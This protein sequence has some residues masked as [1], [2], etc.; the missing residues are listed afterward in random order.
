M[1]EFNE[2]RFMAVTLP[3]L[4]DA[5]LVRAASLAGEIG[6]VN[7]EFAPSTEGLRTA[8]AAL[9]DCPQGL[10]GVRL[11]MSDSMVT[12]AILKDLPQVGWIILSA[13]EPSVACWCVQSFRARGLRVLVETLDVE[14]ARAAEAAGA[15]GVIA[16]GNESGGWVAEEPAFVLLQRL[17]RAVNLPVW[18]QGG[19]G[20]HTSASAFVG[21]AAGVVLDAQ[22]ALLRESPLPD[23]VR[24]RVAT[25][26]GSETV[27]LGEA[28][29]M[30]FRALASPQSETVTALQSLAVRL[31]VGTDTA[32]AERA[33]WR[34]EIRRSV[35]WAPSCLWPL[36]QDAC[37]AR[38]L[39]ERYGT[40]SRALRGLRS[41]LRSEL[42]AAQ[43]VNI[44]MEES[45][46]SKAHGTVYPIVQ[47]PMTRV[48]DTPAFAAE[49]AAAG[50]LPF[51]ALGTQREAELETLLA[52]T[53]RRLDNRPWG[54]GLLGFLDGPL[55]EEQFAVV[56]RHRPP[57]ALIAGGQPEQA[58][59]LE[60]EGIRTY[61]HA[62]TP[63]L[64]ALFREEGA[65]RFVLEGRECGGHVGPLSSF[66]LWEQAARMLLETLPADQSSDCHI[67]LAGGIHDARSAAMAA[68]CMAPLAERG[69]K[70]G[71]LMGTA[72]LF[73]REA[74]SSGAILEVF[75]RQALAC[76]HT[77]LL[78]TG[79]GHVVRCAPTPYTWSFNTLKARRLADGASLEQVRRELEAMNI[80]RLRLAAKGVSRRND[81][82]HNLQPVDENEQ[83]AEGLYMLGQAAGLREEVCTVK[84]L[85]H[86]VSPGGSKILREATR[87]VD[88]CAPRP[89][90]KRDGIAI[91]GMS[92][93]LPGARDP[94]QFWANILN[95]V[96][97]I[98]EVPAERWDWKLY[99]DERRDAADRVYARWGG[100]LDP[101]AFDPARY[102]MPPS[103]IASI[104]PIQLL[105]LETAR[106]A[107]RDAG[108]EDRP[109]PRE[110]TSVIIGVS[111]GLAELGQ[112]YVLRSALAARP[113]QSALA[114]FNRKL[115]EW[116][117]DSFAGILLNVIAGRIANRFDLGGPSFAVDA[118][119]ASSLT[120]VYLACRELE[121]GASDMVLVGGADTFQT[122]FNYLCFCKTQALS[123]R[124]CCRTFD[125]AADG[126]CISEGLSMLVLKRLADA[127]LD[128]DRIYAV[129]R[130]VGASSD[131][132]AKG[133]TAPSPEGQAR[134]LHR[135]YAAANISPA[136]VGLVEAHGTGTV[137][138]DR[139]EIESLRRI[140]EEAG[141]SPQSVALGSVKSMI[142][143]TKG[144]AGVTGLLK[145]ALALHRKVLP[146]TIG[147]EKPN[148]SIAGGA[149]Y[150]NT[151]TRPWLS[152]SQNYPRRAA[153]SGFGFGGAN[154]HVVVEE[155]VG[156]TARAAAVRWPCELFVWRE[157]SVDALLLSVARLLAALRSGA[158][159]SLKDLSFT[160]WQKAQQN[161]DGVVIAIVASS[162]KDLISKMEAVTN[163]LAAAPSNPIWDSSGVYFTPQ[164]LAGN[165][166]IA[167]L[168][169][170]QGSQYPDMLR[171]LAVHFTEVRE[172]FETADRVLAGRFDRPLSSFVFPP[173]R[174]SEEDERAARKALTAT[175]VAQPAL[176]AAAVGLTH[177]LRALNVKPAMTAGH[178]YGEYA[179]LCAA[180]CLTAEQLFEL[181]ESRG[182]FIV[183]AAR[184]DLGAMAA[185][186]TDEQ[187]TRSLMGD[188]TDLWIANLNSP[189]Q[190]IVSGTKAAIAEA[191]RRGEQRRVGVQSLPV[192]CAFHSPLVAAAKERLKAYLD[193]VRF[194]AP[195]YRVFTNTTGN[196]YPTEPDAVRALLG[197]H[198]VSPVRFVSEI[199]SMYAAGARVF[200]EVGP[201]N[202][203]TSLTE[204]ILSQRAS[205]VVPLE[206]RKRVGLEGLLHALAQLFA[207][208]VAIKL[209]RLYEERKPHAYLLERLAEETREKP[210]PA[211]AWWV[212]GGHARPVYTSTAETAK[213]Q[214]S[215]STENTCPNKETTM[216]APLPSASACAEQSR[217][218]D[219]ASALQTHEQVMQQLLDTHRRV[220]LAAL[221]KSEALPE[222]AT[223]AG[224]AVPVAPALA[225]AQ[226][227]PGH[228]TDQSD[229]TDRSPPIA[230]ADRIRQEVLRIVSERTGY[231]PDM[232]DVNADLEADLGIDSI[233]RVEIAGR[234]RKVFPHIGAT[235]ETSR[236]GNLANLRTLNALI[237]RIASVLAAGETTNGGGKAERSM[238]QEGLLQAHGERPGSPPSSA[239]LG[240]SPAVSAGLGSPSVVTGTAQPGAPTAA[241][242]ES[243]PPE[244]N[245]QQKAAEGKLPDSN[246]CF[247]G[248]EA[249]VHVPR[250]MMRFA[251]APSDRKERGGMR[252]DGVFLITDDEKGLADA[253]A[254]HIVS[255]KGKA[256]IVSAREGGHGRVPRYQA[257]FSNPESLHL[258]VTA[259]CKAEGPVAGI[260][261]LLPLRR[262]PVDA[263]SLK[264]W[265]RTL[266]EEVKA[267][268]FLAQ[269][270][271]ED[272]KRPSPGGRGRI[273][274]AVEA[275]DT[276]PGNN[277]I[278]SLLNALTTEWPEV[279]GRSLALDT[280]EA[281]PVLVETICGELQDDASVR[282]VHL[283]NGRRRTVRI[284]TAPL[285]M[286]AAEPMRISS[287]W[288]ILLIGGA[289]GITA[290]VAIELAERFSPTLV[291]T[292]RSPQ[293]ATDEDPLT[294]AVE[295]PPEL[296][297]LLSR[298][299]SE[300][301]G[302]APLAQVEAAY[303]RL[304]REREIRATLAAL[305]ATGARVKYFQADARDSAAFG[306]T[307]DR[308]Y[309]EYGRLDGV[310][311]GAGVIEDKRIEEK[312]P[313]S[314]DRVFDTKA[315][316]AF[317][318]TQRLRLDSV[319]FIVF[320]SSVACLGNAGQSDYAAANGV[321]NG[322]AHDLDRRI[323][324]RVVSILWGPWQNTG[325]TSEEIQR[326]FRERGVQVIPVAAGR[327]CLVAELLYG[328]KGETEVLWG[329]AP[330][331]SATE[332][333]TTGHVTLPLIGK[334]DAVVHNN[335]TSEVACLL[336][337]DQHAYLR[338]HR[339]DGKPVF[340][341]AMAME[342]MAEAAWATAAPPLRGTIE[343][344]SL[345]VQSGIVLAKE[346]PLPLQV[347]GQRAA[348][349][350]TGSDA[351]L[352]TMEI[353]TPKATRRAH[354]RAEVTLGSQAKP[355]HLDPAYFAELDPF[356]LTV[357]E[358]YRQWLFQGPCFAALTA[359]EGIRHDAIVGR[360]QSVKPG[361]CGSAFSNSQW[362]LDPT[363]VDASLQLV[364]LWKRYWHDMTPLPVQISRFR[365]FYPLSNVPIRCFVKALAENDGDSLTADIYYADAQGHVLA[366]LEGLQCACSKELNRLS[367]HAAAQFA[368]N[369]RRHTK[370]KTA[371]G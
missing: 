144:A 370:R 68:A 220:M 51:L 199:E 139:A 236:V 87:T 364:I 348:V 255:L 366:V 106:A 12:P 40:V 105:A 222:S 250:F 207:H 162:M 145:V 22:L 226:A 169:P 310:I 177:L 198:L 323:P 244:V 6:V 192:A 97:A 284:E 357:E 203:L 19:I 109:F 193:R 123:P 146:A 78:E 31:A 273:L 23:A 339:L 163:K 156:S 171:E 183:E 188:I 361:A 34:A 215:A 356:P 66:V 174:F 84:E 101:I 36:G 325:M 147:V 114:G 121:S 202:V 112:N 287:D 213:Q 4:P 197:E 92:C 148:E 305:S 278:T 279:V 328:C 195:R 261:H 37:L 359:I 367:D 289:R 149:L 30:P 225:A 44:L 69:V 165:A 190:T 122:P 214:A 227:I 180:G 98:R 173:P 115:P 206:T 120:A 3:G 179:A 338:D 210:P 58:R 21:G 15:D 219:L 113:D 54:V 41:E 137:A 82:A 72:Y 290:Q 132:R 182:R 230:D 94:D 131:G 349:P 233:K 29:R 152:A 39:A 254:E 70:V 1:L 164:P 196:E 96:N 154:Y 88:E 239:E 184:G 67:L 136:T 292:G 204:Q 365:L 2:F 53:R 52:E 260:V 133:L 308:I 25:M 218:P 252:T 329:D 99:F 248:S 103:S 235:A 125:H 116:T 194:E 369:R 242:V 288:V 221:G 333:A 90:A 336:D 346:E 315:D 95:K 312:T 134:A 161:T 50:A 104:E 160:L 297:R 168:F 61:L 140:F 317:V 56:R 91:V 335:G 110:N 282:F 73:T 249:E 208:G 245:T 48:S 341:V 185:V 157:S 319:K 251:D 344:T 178:S 228:S 7:C 309:A 316:G 59:A 352:F 49:V 89:V 285:V 322:L 246:L 294:R 86:D 27:C 5:T 296:R 268:F 256:V 324:G 209:D 224:P 38:P 270:A 241:G 107:L 217:R 266:Q 81:A 362:L 83:L 262:R 26:D 267:L 46:W 93:L 271:A 283:S 342:L 212:D 295:S 142:G 62:P 311:Y 201:R 253:M 321:L 32:N 291:L 28:L 167:F 13:A 150:I 158:Q 350:D 274:A 176:G 159:P 275:N 313:E 334:P 247:P 135:A 153:V 332:T 237:E 306:Q 102:G 355:P 303:R 200:I 258:L 18:V 117:E 304:R 205:I 277:A 257:N 265:R 45:P 259:V 232:L 269:A 234:L 351:A 264:V 280:S 128:G 240:N 151:E 129:I 43:R 130:G 124:G 9:R 263:P 57:F 293:P 302:K 181:S 74:V 276:F 229:L 76:R 14:E 175:N 111:G 100:F 238:E 108:Y 118:A 143:H 172:A 63:G 326:R 71:V 343:I 327:R 301:M 314:F 8:L 299:L 353:K 191:M 223:S 127:E 17:R 11:D 345:Q 24:R 47:G 331:T 80:G 126:T 79:P 330:Y 371:R 347:T 281:I 337:P 155:Y 60:A 186:E 300:T 286:A 243:G 33:A 298:A 64:L 75:Q 272:L 368:V 360:L 187:N 170:G 10:C 340:P 189:R 307:I 166:N 20:I 55:R 77:V 211:T 42:R 119:C 363:V 320:F 35:G 354:Y 141:A 358:A 16:K 216:N 138:G 85:H 65:R 231:P 318:L